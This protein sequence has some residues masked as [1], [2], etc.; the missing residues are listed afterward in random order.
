MID[1]CG[2]GKPLEEVA[3]VE[4]NRVV[5]RPVHRVERMRW[6]EL[7]SEHHY[8]GFRALPGESVRYVA[9][10]AGEWLA[11]LGWG[12]AAFKFGAR[13]RWIGWTPEQQFK[14]LKFI[15]CNLRFLLLP[16][17]RVPNLASRILSLNVKRLSTDWE[18]FHGHPV[19]L[20]ET[21][22][23]LSRFKG[24]CYRAAGWIPLGE[25]RGF[26]R[27]AGRYFHHGSRKTIWVYPLVRN[28]QCLL[29]SSFLSPQLCEGRTVVDLNTLKLQGKGGLMEVLEKI[30]DPRKR[31]GIRHAQLSILAVAV[32]SCLAGS[33]SFTAMGQ[34]AEELSQNLLQ[35]LGCPWNYAEG[36]YVPPSEPTIRRTVQSVD[37]NDV[38]RRVGAWLAKQNKKDKKGKGLALDGKVLRGSKSADGKPVNLLSAVLHDNATV[39]AQVEVA[40]KSNEIPAVKPLLGSLDIEGM[41][42]TA[43]AL[44]TQV[45]TARFIV[46]DKSADY[47]FTVKGNQPTLMNQIAQLTQAG[48]VSFFPSL[49]NR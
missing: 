23:D 45:E 47:V 44:H 10:I 13:D 9:E 24:T 46:E 18:E 38:D 20:A 14:R 30:K 39:V 32:C 22:V 7:M 2:T 19:V 48:E 6:T 29:S 12:S 27:S 26:G 36:K 35:R 37:A 1:S 11:L 42:V 31:R 15:A 41:V 4:L 25:S 8:L 16:G 40:S 33:K 3:S 49:Q 28:A 5:V 17:R 21:F 43:D 34:W